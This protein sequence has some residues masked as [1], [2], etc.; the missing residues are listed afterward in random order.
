VVGV[1]IYAL[2]CAEYPH[3]PEKFNNP[4]Y[5]VTFRLFADGHA[6]YN[7][8]YLLGLRGTASLVPYLF[9]LV[10]LMV[11]LAMPSRERWRSAALGVGLAALVL[12]SYSLFPGGGKVADAAYDR[13]VAGVMPK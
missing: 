9:G 4:V 11:W 6:A 7:L 1:V 13:W 12:A 8:G 10:A 5:E 3:F 2:S